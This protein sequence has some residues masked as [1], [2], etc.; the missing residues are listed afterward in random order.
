MHVREST[1]FVKADGAGGKEHKKNTRLEIERILGAGCES[2]SNESIG[3][4][5]SVHI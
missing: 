3:E 5:S 1:V 4:K 2:T